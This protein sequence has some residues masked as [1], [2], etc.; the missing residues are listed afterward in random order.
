VPENVLSIVTALISVSGAL[1]SFRFSRRATQHDRVAAAEASAVKFRE[2]LI[3]AAFNLETRLY[4]ILKQ[5]FLGRFLLSDVAVQDR[6][7][8]VDNTLYVLGQYFCWVE[9]IRRES[10]YMDPRDPRRN[11]AVGTQ[12]EE[13]RDVFA[14]SERFEDSVF[15]LFRGE[16]RALGEVMLAPVPEPHDGLPRWECL[17]YAAFV[18][19]L[20]NDEF[21]RWFTQLSEDITAVAKEPDLHRDRLVRAQNALV[22]LIEVLDPAGDRIQLKFRE[23]L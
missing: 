11:R 2:P 12:L 17:G 19:A 21:G 22:G 4:N 13:I 1:I 5:D 8:A 15:R 20:R 9:I 23:R 16:Q 7:Y 6:D 14:S 18:T 3:Q 10:Q